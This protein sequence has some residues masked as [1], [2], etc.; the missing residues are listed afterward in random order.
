MRTLAEDVPARPPPGQ[1]HSSCVVSS[2]AARDPGLNPRQ[3][4]LPVMSTAPSLARLS[5]GPTERLPCH[6]L[7]S[8]PFPFST[9]QNFRSR[10]TGITQQRGSGGIIPIQTHLHIHPSWKA[11]GNSPFP[12]LHPETRA[13]AKRLRGF[14]K[15]CD[16]YF[17]QRWVPNTQHKLLAIITPN[18]GILSV[19]S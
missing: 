1:V 4:W 15:L 13:R 12:R 19:F 5:G 3:G 17:S 2:Q 14:K 16:F 9:S 8:H 7:C 18:R 10:R 6:V 11:S